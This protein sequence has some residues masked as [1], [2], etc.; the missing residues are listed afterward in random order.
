MRLLSKILCTAG[1]AVAMV[2]TL[3]AAGAIVDTWADPSGD[4]LLDLDDSPAPGT[5]TYAYQHDITDDGFTIGE[6]IISATL[7]LTVRDSGGSESY[8]YELGA[9]PAQV[10]AFA[11]VPN[12]RIDQITLSAPSLADLQLDGLLDVVIRITADSSRQEGLYFVSSSLSV[13]TATA[14]ASISNVP[15]PGTTALVALAMVLGWRYRRGVQ[16]HPGS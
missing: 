12:S 16:E 3:P 8:Q 14:T 11:N 5:D 15:E 7:F 10:S 6:S 9:G 2:V 1:A 13:D 4:V